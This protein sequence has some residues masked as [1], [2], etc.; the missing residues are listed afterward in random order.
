[1]DLLSRNNLAI[2]IRH[3]FFIDVESSNAKRDIKVE[4]IKRLRN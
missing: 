2:S 3:V 4:I 1:M